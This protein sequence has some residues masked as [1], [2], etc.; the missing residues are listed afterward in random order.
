MMEKTK[1]Y[2]T[3]DYD[4]YILNRE[5]MERYCPELL[6]EEL[7]WAV[8][9]IFPDEEKAQIAF[10][11]NYPSPQI[12]ANINM[13]EDEEDYELALEFVQDEMKRL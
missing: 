13:W 4:Q 9:E 8:L 7:K 3:Y 2:E 5:E 12:C 10:L 1:D 11:E 6:G